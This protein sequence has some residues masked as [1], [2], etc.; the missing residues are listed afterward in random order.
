MQI[1]KASNFFILKFLSISK[2]KPE[3]SCSGLLCRLRRR[4]IHYFSKNKLTAD[5]LSISFL[6][7]LI[8]RPPPRVCNLIVICQICA[9]LRKQIVERQ[10]KVFTDRAAL[11]RQKLAAF[12]LS[13]EQGTAHAYYSSHILIRQMV[14]CFHAQEIGEQRRTT[15]LKLFCRSSSAANSAYRRNMRDSRYP[16]CIFGALPNN[17]AIISAYRQYVKAYLGIS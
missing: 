11:L 6:L 8:N 14:I 9:A 10:V 4:V 3:L 16:L 5:G 15:P 17:K 13:A 1:N 12:H 7:T 2:I